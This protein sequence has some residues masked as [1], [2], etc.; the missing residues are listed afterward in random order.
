MGYD[1]YPETVSDYDE[2]NFGRR[3]AAIVPAAGY[4]FRSIP[5]WARCDP[6]LDT[7]AKPAMRDLFRDGTYLDLIFDTLIGEGVVSKILLFIGKRPPQSFED[8]RGE[9]EKYIFKIYKDLMEIGKRR[10]KEVRIFHSIPGSDFGS[11]AALISDEGKQVLSSMPEIDYVLIHYGDVPNIPPIKLK[12]TVIDHVRYGNSLTVVST[13]VDDPF[14]YGRIARYPLTALGIVDSSDGYGVLDS[15][16]QEFNRQVREGETIMIEIPEVDINRHGLWAKYLF[17]RRSEYEGC[18]DDDE[19]K[20]YHPKRDCLERGLIKLKKREI[21]KRRVYLERDQSV[22]W[23]PRSGEFLDVKE[24]EEIGRTPEEREKI[25]SLKVWGTDYPI[26]TDYIHSIKERNTGLRVMDRDVVTGAF[27]DMDAPNYARVIRDESGAET[28]L[29]PNKLIKSLDP[30]SL[31]SVKGRKFSKE[32]LDLITEC[33]KLEESPPGVCVLERHPNDEYYLPEIQEDIK[34]RNGKI[35]LFMIPK[36]IVKGYDSRT[37]ARFAAISSNI[38]LIST[39]RKRDVRVSDG[40]TFRIGQGF[41]AGRIEPGASLSGNVVLYGK[42]R[43][44]A[45]TLLEDAEI[46]NYYFNSYDSHKRQLSIRNGRRGRDELIIG[47]DGTEIKGSLIVNSA[48]GER[49]NLLNSEVVG[50]D[51]ELGKVIRDKV[52]RIGSGGLPVNMSF[53]RNRIKLPLKG[54]IKLDDYRELRILE[55]VYA[56]TIWP[57][58]EIFADSEIADFLKTMYAMVRESGGAKRFCDLY[59]DNLSRDN[60]GSIPGLE[61]FRETSFYIGAHTTLS[62]TVALK[63]SIYIRP[64]SVINNSFLEDTTSGRNAHIWNSILKKCKISSDIRNVTLIDSEKLED[65]EIP[66]GYPGNVT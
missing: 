12:E 63:G 22:I 30:Y 27:R 18:G 24:Q 54:L 59:R 29:I 64:W 7:V 42:I 26:S 11:G 50:V 4:G 36:G 32:D 52:I 39:L 14:N 3:V 44:R 51:I 47:G 41:D 65:R 40:T 25:G 17:L 31:F 61:R 55:E 43:I 8:C 56:A 15:K 2:L 28:V 49:V 20:L 1:G 16:S 46:V 23:H 21:E 58:T 6:F 19:I 48:V 5:A 62:G 57:W 9:R 37:E 33:R 13:T 53:S 35:G 10:Y 60:P 45:G 66:A 34:A 38:E